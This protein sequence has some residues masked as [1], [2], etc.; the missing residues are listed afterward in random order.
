MT[1]DSYSPTDGT[2][3]FV[4]DDIFDQFISLLKREIEKTIRA[5]DPLDVNVNF[6]P[7]VSKA[8]YEKVR[9]TSGIALRMTAQLFS[10]AASALPLVCLRNLKLAT[11]S[12]RWYLSTVLNRCGLRARKY[13][14]PLPASCISQRLTKLSVAQTIRSWDSPPVFSLSTSTLYMRL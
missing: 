8:Q 4:H 2:R 11:S 10:L 12:R 13:S 3:V 5:G 14:V 6:G 1:A 7:V 9:G